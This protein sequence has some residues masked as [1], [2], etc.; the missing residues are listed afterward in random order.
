MDF[1]KKHYEKVILSF[2]LACLAVTAALLPL[3][4]AAV[5]NDLQGTTRV[6]GKGKGKPIKPLDLTTNEAALAK[7]RSSRPVEFS[8]QGHYVFN[9]IMWVKGPGGRKVP[10][11]DTGLASLIVTNIAP[12]RTQITYQEARPSGATTRYLFVIVREAS[13]NSSHWR[14]F[15]RFVGGGDRPNEVFT[16]KEVRGPL[17]DP[18]EFVI[19]L[20]GDS[21]KAVTVAKDR[22]YSEVAGFAAD[23]RHELDNRVFLKQRQGQRLTIAGMTYNIVAI[24]QFDVTLEDSQTKKRTTIR[25]KDKQ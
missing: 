9:P 5:N 4:V 12:L 22:P 24:S 2:V 18:T 14:P 11:E 23:L 15:Q 19:E 6:I 17:D 13:T 21:G 16:L 20:T 1:L 10:K 3:K 7:V 8:E 25:L